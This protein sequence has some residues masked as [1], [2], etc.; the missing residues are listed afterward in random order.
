MPLL[1]ALRAELAHMGSDLLHTEK[2]H[3]A[4]AQKHLRLHRWLGVLATLAGALA[5][6]AVVSNRSKTVAA[7]LALTASMA[8]GIVTFV[9]PQE[10]AQQHLD[11]GRDLGALRVRVRQALELDLAAPD[12]NL[13]AAR[14]ATARFADQKAA[15]DKAAP[16]LTDASYRAGK[17]KIDAG[18]F[19]P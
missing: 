16:A 8:S 18:E 11:G 12:P 19:E 15:I 10:K 2:G 4:A 17:A 7:L 13:E 6:A 14:K 1:E 9:K 3:F 5:A